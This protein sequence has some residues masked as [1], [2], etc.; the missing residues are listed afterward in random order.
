MREEISHNDVQ[1]YITISS[2]PKKK[3]YRSEQYCV[4]AP[5]QEKDGN[6][7]EFVRMCSISIDPTTLLTIWHRNQSGRDAREDG[8]GSTLDFSTNNQPSLQEI[9]SQQSW[10][11]LLGK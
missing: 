3:K 6:L 2:V 11:K 9:N 8:R 4:A 10:G 1:G 5:R 7:M